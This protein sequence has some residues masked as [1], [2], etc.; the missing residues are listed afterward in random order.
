MINKIN[1]TTIK[2][3]PPPYPPVA[4]INHTPITIAANTV[5]NLTNNEIDDQP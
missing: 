4:V 1:N 3:N 2:A 5:C